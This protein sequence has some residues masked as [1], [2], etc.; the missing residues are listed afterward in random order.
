[1]HI[2]DVL[3]D[4]QLKAKTKVELISSM[5]V[6]GKAKIGDVID[7]AKTLKGSEKGTCIEAIEFATRSK[8]ELA[9]FDC[10]KFVT[11]SLNDSAPRVRWESAKVIANIA[12]LYP[13]KLDKAIGNLLTN[14]ESS[15][16]VV[17]W[18]AAKALG[19]IIKLRTKHNTD[20]VPAI[21]AII[22]REDDSA[23]K[24]IYRTALGALAK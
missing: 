7:T 22:R 10:L 15:G 14:T 17:R 18:S 23:I 11:E 20:L 21:D 1:M 8:S 4:K 3:A 6:D 12:H 5:L 2:K 24:K 19:E 16:T 13:G 9:T